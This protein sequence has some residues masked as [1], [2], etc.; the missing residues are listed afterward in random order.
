MATCYCVGRSSET[1]PTVQRGQT[2]WSVRAGLH[3]SLFSRSDDGE[4]A[5][6]RGDAQESRA[7][8]TTLKMEVEAARATKRQ[9]R[10]V[11]MDREALRDD[12]RTLLEERTMLQDMRKTLSSALARPINPLPGTGATTSSAATPATRGAG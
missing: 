4:E 8:A 1:G 7:H 3:S 6:S 5:G 12:L 10:D 9:L 2:A 11:M